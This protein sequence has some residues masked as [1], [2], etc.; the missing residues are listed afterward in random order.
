MDCGDC[1]ERLYAFL[2]QELTAAEVVQVKGHLDDCGGCADSFVF[3]STSSRR[4]ATAA[5]GRALRR[6]SASASSCA[7]AR[8]VHR[9]PDHPRVSEV[10]TFVRH[11]WLTYAQVVA[12]R[13]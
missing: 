5:P 2:D 9:P 12:R 1:L 8:R 3:G 11:L 4:C 7:S 6:N 10:L 13:R